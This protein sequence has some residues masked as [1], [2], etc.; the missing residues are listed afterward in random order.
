MAAS[1]LGG[2]A[3]PAAGLPATVPRIDTTAAKAQAP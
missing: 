3:V 2:T 1:G